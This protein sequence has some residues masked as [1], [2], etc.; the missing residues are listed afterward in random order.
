MI[1]S[2]TNR[3]QKYKKNSNRLQFLEIIYC[4]P[5]ANTSN[6]IVADRFVRRI[7][8]GEPIIMFT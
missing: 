2:F 6:P 5:K 3:R 7:A 4:S 8:K 1:H